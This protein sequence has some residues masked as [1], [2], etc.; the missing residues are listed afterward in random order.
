MAHGEGAL[1][2]ITS[3]AARFPDAPWSTTPPPRPPCCPSR[4]RSRPSSARATSAPT[5]WL[6]AL[7]ARACGTSPAASPSSS[8][9]RSTSRSRRR[10]NTSSG[11]SGG[12][13][14]GRIGAPDDVARIVAYLLLPPGRSGDRSRMGSG[15]RSPPRALELTSIK[16][17]ACDTSHDRSGRCCPRSPSGSSP[18]SLPDVRP[19]RTLTSPA[20]RA[21]GRPRR[22][23]RARDRAELVGGRFLSADRASDRTRERRRHG[24]TDS[25]VQRVRHLPLVTVSAVT[26]AR[27]GS[28]AAVRDGFVRR[29]TFRRSPSV[30]IPARREVRSDAVPFR[31]SPLGTAHRDAVLRGHDRPGDLPLPPG[32]RRPTGRR[33][34]MSPTGP[35]PPS[36]TG[37][38]PGTTC[39][40]SRRRGADSARDGRR[41]R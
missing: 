3:E 37:P 39:R 2:H 25:A 13:P 22:S 1:V 20:G 23:D 28:G 32:L 41:L 24:R 29:L 4:R 30:S 26:I 38:T 35:G 6:R 10:S 19:L 7:P 16:E 21:P 27:V 12:C 33:E 40:G 17:K 9:P 8:P 34:I 5:S 18:C 36:P 15:R 31:V 11:T 14:S